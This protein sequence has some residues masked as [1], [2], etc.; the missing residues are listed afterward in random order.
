MKKI[1]Y[2]L[3][4]IIIIAA[5]CGFYAYQVSAQQN[6]QVNMSG[7]NV[8]VAYY[9][10]SGNTKAVAQKIQNVTGGDLF[11]ITPK[12]AYPKDYGTV[13][14]QARTEKDNDTR[15]E[16]VENGNIAEYDVIFLGTPVWWYTMAP[17]VKTFL[18]KNDFDGKIIVPFCTHGGGGES[19]TYTDMQKLAPN[20]KVVQGFT[21]YEHTASENDVKKW[22]NNLNL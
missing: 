7:K 5:S 11:E 17:P 13:V 22:I 1:W 12:K 16:L 21:S 3:A 6:E 14:E 4:I 9:S 8:L 10:Y 18:T 15:P 20:A 19:A 2:F